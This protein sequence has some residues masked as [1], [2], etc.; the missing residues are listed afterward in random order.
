MK[1]CLQL[2]SSKEFMHYDEMYKIVDFLN[3]NLSDYDIAF[4][5]A[6]KDGKSIISIYKE[7]D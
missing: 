2:I 3:K 6:E 4:G 1:D 7:K 5:V